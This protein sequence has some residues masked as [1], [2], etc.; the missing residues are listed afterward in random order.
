MLL[1]I[2]LLLGIIGSGLMI[3]EDY[4][5]MVK[6]T[7]RDSITLTVG[8]VMIYVVIS[9]LGP[10]TLWM[11]LSETTII[12]DLGDLISPVFDI[13]VFTFRKKSDDESR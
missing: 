12:K 11:A 8:D 1:T 3:Y 5:S 9:L 6:S 2:W 13:P 10:F 7:W 4:K